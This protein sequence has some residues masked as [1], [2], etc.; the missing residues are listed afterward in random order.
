MNRVKSYSLKPLHTVITVGLF[1]VARALTTEEDYFVF[2][3]KNICI[4]QFMLLVLLGMYF[5][6]TT[7]L[8]QKQH[9]KHEKRTTEKK[10]EKRSKENEDLLFHV[11]AH[12]ECVH[13]NGC[14]SGL[15]SNPKEGKTRTKPRVLRACQKCTAHH[16]KWSG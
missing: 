7:T 1:P 11:S 8:L 3:W 15:K 10:H 16:L 12:G 5:I 9:K 2:N 6:L 4:I 13:L 14:R